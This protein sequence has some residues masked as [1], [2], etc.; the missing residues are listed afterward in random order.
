MW[1]ELLCRY[2]HFLGIIVL[3]SMLVAEHMLLKGQ[4]NS[5]EIK[6]LAVIDA[7]YGISALVV[8]LAGLSLWLWTGKPLDFYSSNIVF[9]SKLSAFLLMALLSIYPT[10]FLMKHRKNKT[11]SVAVPKSIVM[12]LR[13]E[14]MLLVIIP[15]LAVLMARGV[16][17]NG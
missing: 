2:A 10:L 1:F 4:L 12:V 17:L 11:E 6:R 15:L 9:H 14:L 3:A 13:A 8:F 5:K 7:S 16:G